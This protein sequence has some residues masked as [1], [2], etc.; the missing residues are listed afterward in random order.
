MFK[1]LQ[2]MSVFLRSL[3]LLFL[4]ALWGSCHPRTESNSGNKYVKEKPPQMIEAEFPRIGK[5]RL[6][7]DSNTGY[8]ETRQYGYLLQGLPID[9]DIHLNK[10]NDQAIELISQVLSDLEQIYQ[11]GQSSIQ[12][13]FEEGDVVKDYI[14]EW[15]EDIFLQIFEEKE[16]EAFIGETDSAKSMEERLLSLIRLVRVGVYAK[17]ENEFLVLDFAFGYDSEQGFRD[18]MIVLWLNE[19]Y[20]VVDI[21]VEG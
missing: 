17:S 6:E 12:E 21:G 3:D 2:Y 5:V 4:V 11:I 16:F 19:N 20:K 1:Q 18:D 13:D 10:V 9:L 7:K 14:E 15:K 8:F